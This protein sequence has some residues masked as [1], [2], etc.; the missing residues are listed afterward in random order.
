MSDVTA[1]HP[2]LSVLLV[3]GIIVA[4][5][6]ASVVLDGLVHSAVS[7]AGR[8]WAVPRRAVGR[9]ALRWRQRGSTTER[10]DVTLWSLSPGFYAA[11]AAAAIAV[12]P[13]AEG[14]A[15]ADVRTGI[16]VFGAVEVLTMVAVYLHG[17]SANSYVS[18]IGGYRFVAVVL[19]T[20]LISMFV[21]IAAALPAESLSFGAIVASQKHLWN[22][23]RQP[24]GLPLWLVAGLATA[25]WGPLQLPDAADLAGGTSAETS[26]PQRLVWSAARRSMLVAYAVA[27]AAVFLGGH[28]GPWLPGWS[29]M[30]LKTLT[31]LWLLIV[32]GHLVGRVRPERV[33]TVAWTGLLPA[34]FIHL[35]QAGVVALVFAGR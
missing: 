15:A 26:G 10:P 18:M 4:G 6:A 23:V 24:L 16:V 8:W 32:C 33:V 5:V 28:H 17:W 31:V 29:W 13:V 30:I 9:A 1:V 7:G 27:G 34:S 19:S 25:F 14:V 3:G 35:V 20:L 22:V 21:L 11:C 12:V 2:A